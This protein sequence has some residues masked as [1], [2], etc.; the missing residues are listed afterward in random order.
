MTDNFDILLSIA[1]TSC[2]TF[3][4]ELALHELRCL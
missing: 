4:C 3:L 2:I 1:D